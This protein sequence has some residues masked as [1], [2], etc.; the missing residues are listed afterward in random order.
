[1]V[2]LQLTGLW[3]RQAM[4]VADLGADGTSMQ[5]ARQRLG[6]VELDATGTFNTARTEITLQYNVYQL[7]VTQA[8]DVC[9]ATLTKS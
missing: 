8:F 2:Q 3:G 9:N 7:G 1:M 5:I 6:N 4:I